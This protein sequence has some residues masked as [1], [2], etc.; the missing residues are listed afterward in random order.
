M[1]IQKEKIARMILNTSIIEYGLHDAIK[2]RYFNNS[3]VATVSSNVKG[4][5]SD[6]SFTLDDVLLSGA[7]TQS[8]ILLNGSSG[9][10]KTFLTE[11][12]SEYLFGKG[13][14]ARKNI[15]PDM[16]E[17]DFMDIDFGAIKEG[18]RLKEALLADKVLACPA[19]IIDEANR[20]PPIIQNRLMQILEN[21]I[22][23]KSKKIKAGVELENND[24]YQWVLLTLNIGSEYAGTSAIDR[25]LRD[26]IT[27]DIPIDNFPPTIEDQVKMVRKDFVKGSKMSRPEGIEE[28][29]YSIYQDLDAIQLSLEAEAFI[30]YLSFCSNCVHSPTFTKYGVAFS[31]LFCREKDCEYARNPP[32]NKICPFTFAPS[33]RVLRRIVKVAKGFYLVR[34]AKIAQEIAARE[35]IDFNSIDQDFIVGNVQQWEVSLKEVISIAPLILHSKVSMNREWVN[36]EYNG[37]SFLAAMEYIKVAANQL[38]NFMKSVLPVLVKRNKGESVTKKEEV[39]ADRMIKDD[40]HF[41][42]LKEYVDKYLK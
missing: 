26:R 35:N 24:Y 21:D 16:N 37:N 22:D 20:A 42:G 17:Q 41:K 15:T 19:F 27:I 1:T 6:I 34:Q 38:A 4:K 40:F 28:L 8:S 39:T 31:P 33:N 25:A 11:L 10:G 14:Y 23:L 30:L 32:L 3:K 18:K 9:S 29:I 7:M 12:V 5:I 13:N 36:N 2:K